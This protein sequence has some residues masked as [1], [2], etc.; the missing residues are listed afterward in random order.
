[1][2]EVTLS[3][4]LAVGGVHKY[5]LEAKT[6]FGRERPPPHYTGLIHATQCVHLLAVT[7][8]AMM[9]SFSTRTSVICC[10]KK[11]LKKETASK[12]QI[13]YSKMFYS[14]ASQVESFIISYKHL[15]YT[16]NRDK[17]R[18]LQRNIY[19]NQF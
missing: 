9:S 10:K 14:K 6:Y 5:I 8:S 2:E 13:H 15:V 12:N 3:D 16:Q 17:V 4:I 1:M 11:P 19:D 18:S 7:G